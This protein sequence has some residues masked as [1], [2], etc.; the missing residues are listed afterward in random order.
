MTDQEA[1][2]ALTG[3]RVTNPRVAAIVGEWARHER[4][5]LPPRAREA[6]PEG[7]R[8]L[9]LKAARRERRRRKVAGG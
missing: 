2:Q 5:R 1:K 6:I 9:V 7:W 8:E 4:L 3:L